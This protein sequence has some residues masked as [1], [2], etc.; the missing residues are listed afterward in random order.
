MIIMGIRNPKDVLYY[1][2]LQF[3]VYLLSFTCCSMFN[4]KTKNTFFAVM[5]LCYPFLWIRVIVNIESKSFHLMFT[6]CSLRMFYLPGRRG[7]SCYDGGDVTEGT[8]NLMRTYL[9]SFHSIWIKMLLCYGSCCVAYSI[10]CSF[11]DFRQF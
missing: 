8:L 2:C 10:P 5:L 7:V 3:T 9:E 11:L 4:T 1:T 6:F